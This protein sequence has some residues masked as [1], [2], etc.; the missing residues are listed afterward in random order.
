MLASMRTPCSC[1]T[2]PGTGQVR[3]LGRPLSRLTEWIDGQ[4]F[5]YPQVSAFFK[6][7]D[8]LVAAV[9]CWFP[10]S[11]CAKE[12]G[13]KSLATPFPVLIFYPGQQG[14]VQYRGPLRADL[15]TRW[16]GWILWPCHVQWVA[17]RI[18]N[19]SN[20]EIS[21]FFVYRIVYRIEPP[22]S[23]ISIF[24]KPMNFLSFFA[25]NSKNSLKILKIRRKFAENSENSPKILKIR[26]KFAENS[27]NSPKIPQKEGLLWG[28][29]IVSYRIVSKKKPSYRI[30]IVSNQ[31]KAYRYSVLI[32]PS[33]EDLMPASCRWYKWIYHNPVVAENR[34]NRR[35]DF[36][37][38][39]AA[40]C[41]F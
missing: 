35:F 38:F 40:E 34:V 33:T 12:F 29:H 41:L 21:D 24:S 32:I 15:V 7:T 5:F 1:S 37:D 27:E 18:G 20:A 14:G 30:D 31:K 2:L 16:V 17:Y 13:N 19:L 22:I 36:S 25:E 28:P 26:R 10:T 8:I 39:L 3:R 6:H 9:N 4:Y 11:D 23:C